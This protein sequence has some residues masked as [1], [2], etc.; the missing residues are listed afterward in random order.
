MCVIRVVGG[1]GSS[2]ILGSNSIPEGIR[3]HALGYQIIESFQN[4]K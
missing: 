4:N 2:R 3:K 1:A